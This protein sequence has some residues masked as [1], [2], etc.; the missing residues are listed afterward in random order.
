M[1][2]R[3]FKLDWSYFIGE[4]AIVTIGVL[5]ALGIDGWNDERLDRAEEVEI[6]SRLIADIN[7]DFMFLDFRLKA[8]DAKEDSLRR[9]RA[10]FV[11][12]A[13]HDS[14]AFLRDIIAG[15]DFG[16]NQGLAQRATFDDLLGSGRLQVITDPDI[17]TRIVVY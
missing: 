17:R 10:A 14:Y 15:A 7:S 1:L 8:I 2:W 13:P 16:W 4:L 3:K 12:G 6:I 5:I 9:V 11:N